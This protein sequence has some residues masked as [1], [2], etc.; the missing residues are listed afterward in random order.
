M[1]NQVFD[2]MVIGGGASGMAAAIFAARQGCRVLVL[3]QKNLQ[4]ML[5]MFRELMARSGLREL[6][7]ARNRLC[8]S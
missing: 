8:L 2:T 5:L 4:R 6:C 3:E 7:P 1:K